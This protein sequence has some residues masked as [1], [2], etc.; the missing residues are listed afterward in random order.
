[1]KKAGAG[2]PAPERRCDI[3]KQEVFFRLSALGAVILTQ[4][5]GLSGDDAEMDP[6]T[7]GAFP[8]TRR[9]RQPVF[10]HSAAIYM[11]KGAF[12]PRAAL[13]PEECMARAPCPDARRLN[14]EDLQIA[15]PHIADNGAVD[16]ERQARGGERVILAVGLQ[17]PFFEIHPTLIDELAWVV[18]VGSRYNIWRVEFRMRAKSGSRWGI[19]RGYCRFIGS[20]RRLLQS[21][22]LLAGKKE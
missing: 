17:H 2:E 3:I 18:A 10:A 13:R 20:I 7:S 16:A 14:A 6:L 15:A 1:M 22:A 4:H 8:E 21:G 19:H 11:H 12:R 9:P 5:K